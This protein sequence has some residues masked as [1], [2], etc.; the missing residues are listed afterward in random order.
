MFHVKRQGVSRLPGRN[1]ETQRSAETQRK[2]AKNLCNLRFCRV[3][4]WSFSRFVGEGFAIPHSQFAFS[5]LRNLRFVCI[6]AAKG[7]KMV[8]K[9]AKK[10][11][12]IGG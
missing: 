12:V 9:D 2:S 7:A 11:G 6:L 3:V 4:G 1:T 8:A 10:I 5:H